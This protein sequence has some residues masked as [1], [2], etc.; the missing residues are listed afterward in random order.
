MSCSNNIYDEKIEIKEASWA[1]VD[2][3]AFTFEIADTS[4]RYN[5]F[6][7][8][9]HQPSY[10]FQ[11][12]YCLVETY[13]PQGLSQ[14]QVSS[15]ELA[16]RKGKWLGECD[17]EQCER[18]IPFIVNTLFDEA[19][20]YKIVLKQYSRPALLQGIQSLRLEVAPIDG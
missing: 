13:G 15:L 16:S 20:K 6:L 11:N 19:G 8:V 5:I 10:A 9:N 1:E 12:I 3:V 18:R 2:S 4:Q 7:T 14:R 17:A